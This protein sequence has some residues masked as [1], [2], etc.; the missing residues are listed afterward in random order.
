MRVPSEG[1][2]SNNGLF[3]AWLIGFTAALCLTAGYCVPR[4]DAEARPSLYSEQARPV[5]VEQ[6][7]NPASAECDASQR[8]LGDDHRQ[9]GL[10]HKQLVEVASQGAA[11]GQHDAAVRDVRAEF[12]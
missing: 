11:A 10:F 2:R 7:E 12:R 8:V 6:F 5:L 3:S 9:A 4:T 1:P